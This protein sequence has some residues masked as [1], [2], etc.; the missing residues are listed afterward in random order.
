T[1]L[2]GLAPLGDRFRT[3]KAKEADLLMQNKALYDMEQLSQ[4]G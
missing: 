4:V 2:E 3:L 1:I